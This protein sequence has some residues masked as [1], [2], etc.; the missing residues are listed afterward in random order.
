MFKFKL[1]IQ[2]L[3]ELIRV[4]FKEILTNK[5]AI[6]DLD[7][8]SKPVDYQ[9]Q[10]P[11]NEISKILNFNYETDSSTNVR[12]N[13][14]WVDYILLFN[15]LFNIL[16]NFLYII[17]DSNDQMFRLYC[18]DLIQSANA[19]V[20]FVAI[21]LVGFTGFSTSMFCMFHYLSVNQLKWLNIFNAVEG[22]QSFVK[23][24]ILMTKSAKEFIRICLIFI[25]FSITSIYF[26]PISA[27]AIL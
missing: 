20:A 18:S 10:I 4:P 9:Y 6:N 19:D 24:K 23:T 14:N 21:A 17:L 1:R 16:R 25:T 7:D 26:I 15:F 3:R 5:F 27:F 11:I 13:E 2:I 8:L 12:R 22:K